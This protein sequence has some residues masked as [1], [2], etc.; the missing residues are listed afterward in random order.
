MWAPEAEKEGAVVGKKVVII[1]GGAVG[2][3]AAANLASDGKEVT[4]VEI[5][6][7]FN[8]SAS[9]MGVIGGAPFLMQ[10]LAEKNAALLLKH[11]VERIDEKTVT[12]VDVETGE[13]KAIEADTVLYCVGMKSLTSE[14]QSFRGSAPN[15]RLYLVGDCYD[16]AEIRGAVRT[17]FDIAAQL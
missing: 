9:I 4:V 8:L 1:G 13:E 6:G 10:E 16:Q 15:T 12:L 3:Q 7:E 14:A 2:I 17:A 11:R 5:A